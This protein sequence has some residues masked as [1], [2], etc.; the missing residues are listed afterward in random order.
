MCTGVVYTTHV[1]CTGAKLDGVSCTAA[2]LLQAVFPCAEQY[3]CT[4]GLAKW[5]R[6]VVATSVTSVAESGRAP[7]RAW[8]GWGHSGH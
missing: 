7:A 3:L 1:W 4:I 8:V 6:N 2:G 5:H